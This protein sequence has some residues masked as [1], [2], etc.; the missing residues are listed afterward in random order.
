[1]AG[2]RMR[3]GERCIQLRLERE[4]RDGKRGE[5]RREMRGEDGRGEESRGEERYVY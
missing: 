3:R 2:E 1:M 4:S 5:E